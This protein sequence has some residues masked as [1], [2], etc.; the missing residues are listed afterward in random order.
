LKAEANRM[1]AQA[2]ESLQGFALHADEYFESAAGSSF[3]GWGGLIG[4]ALVGVLVVLNGDA[5]LTL[6]SS[7][8]S[9]LQKQFGLIRIDQ[10]LP[11]VAFP[12][13]LMWHS[14]YDRD[15]CHQWVR[16]ELAKIAQEIA[17]AA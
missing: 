9:I 8:A 3:M 12:L 4:S 10:P 15:E 17:D 13:R 16:G 6:P 7:L 5:L 1:A 14:S 2:T 11:P